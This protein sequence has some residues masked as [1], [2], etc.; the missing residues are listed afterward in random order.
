VRTR[1]NDFEDTLHEAVQHIAE[2]YNVNP[3]QLGLWYKGY[4][5]STL[6]MT[7]TIKSYY[8]D[9]LKTTLEVYYV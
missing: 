8:Q 4:C 9:F 5:D 1:I 6:N 7:K 2:G 3:F